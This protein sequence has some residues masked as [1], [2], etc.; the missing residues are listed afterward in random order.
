MSKADYKTP[1]SKTPVYYSDFLTDFSV[2]PASHQLARVTNETA[3]AQSVSNIILTGPSERFYK[4]NYGPGIKRLLFEQ[5][6]S[7]T[8]STIQTLIENAIANDEPRAQNVV[9]S[10]QVSPDGKAY[11]VTVD[12]STINTTATTTVSVVLQRVR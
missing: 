5:A 2:N 8:A 10:V 9:V 4:L 7:A 11:F 6:D 12:F 3:V 1:A